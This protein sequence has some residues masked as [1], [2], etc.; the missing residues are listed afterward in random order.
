[1]AHTSWNNVKSRRPLSAE[2]QQFY[3]EASLVI[4]VADQVRKLRVSKG[5]SQEELARRVGTTQPMIARLESAGQPPSLRTLG[6]LAA[7]LDA[8][9]SVHLSARGSIAPS[10]P[11][12]QK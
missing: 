11:S 8:E 3:D 10:F 4:Q 7:A 9:L 6:R 2:G 12:I 1:M 5:L